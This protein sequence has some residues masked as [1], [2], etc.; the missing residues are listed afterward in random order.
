MAQD[1]Y[2]TLGVDRSADAAALKAAF[3][4][5]AMEHHPDRNGGCEN[6]AAKFKEIN[7]A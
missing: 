6:S 3:R 7:E 4:K 5:A 2:Q 1:Y